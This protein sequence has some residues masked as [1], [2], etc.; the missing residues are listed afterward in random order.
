IKRIDREPVTTTQLLPDLRQI[1]F[2]NAEQHVDW[3]QLGDDE[4]AVGIGGM[5][6]VA[7]IDQTQTDSSGDRRSD[8][9][10]GDLNFGVV[11]LSLIDVYDALILMDRGDLCVELLL[12][13]RI[14]AIGDLVT[15]EI[16]LC[17]FKQRLIA[18]KLSLG[19][20]QLRLKRTRIDLRQQLALF[21]HLTFTIIDTHQLTIHTAFDSHRVERRNRTECIDVHADVAFLS[22]GRR[23]RDTWR[24]RRRFGGSDSSLLSVLSD[25]K[26]DETCEEKQS[27]HEPWLSSSPARSGW[28][29]IILFNKGLVHSRDLTEDGTFFF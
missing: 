19:L 1:I 20:G 16:D 27:E 18:L 13:D 26:T 17:V 25:Q 28:G 23:Y 10:I 11:D 4:H 15:V 24:R 29:Y 14:L 8:A 9:A 12:R 5:N 6:D 22:N 21:D 2:G 3:L 7:R